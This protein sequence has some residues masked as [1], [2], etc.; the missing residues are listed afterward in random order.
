VKIERFVGLVSFLIEILLGFIHKQGFNQ[1][2]KVLASNE[3]KF[4]AMP[5]EQS[6]YL[7]ADG[8]LTGQ[9]IPCLLC[10]PEVHYHV[11]KSPAL[12]F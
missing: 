7:N 9:E 11:H 1:N 6:P 8:H 5:M 10:I 3:G 4:I 12:F 2:K